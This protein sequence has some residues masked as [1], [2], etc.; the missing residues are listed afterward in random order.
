MKTFSS[1]PVF[2][3]SLGM[4]L[5]EKKLNGSSAFINLLVAGS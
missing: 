5:S 2:L 4:T 3:A 1:A